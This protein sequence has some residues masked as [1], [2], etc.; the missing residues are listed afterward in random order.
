MSKPLSASAQK[1]QTSLAAGGFACEIV[2]VPASTRTASEAAAA[3]GC[4]LAQIAKSLLFKTRH[5]GRPVLVVAS[6]TNRVNEK[7]LAAKLGEAIEKSNADFVREK[8]GFVIGGVPPLGHAEPLLTYL[9]EDLQQYPEIWAAGGS[10]TAVF[11]LTPIELQ[12]MS[13]G[14]WVRVH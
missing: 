14:Q 12:N 5:T 8:T 6:G 4:S 11:R 1:V 13:G 3:I 7:A 10:P 9:D 2:E